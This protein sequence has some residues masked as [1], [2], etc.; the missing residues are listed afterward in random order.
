MEL[1]LSK[2][3]VKPSENMGLN[4]IPLRIRLREDWLVVLKFFDNESKK[5]YT[6]VRGWLRFKQYT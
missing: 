4:A 5:I 6:D 3:G 2:L 1:E